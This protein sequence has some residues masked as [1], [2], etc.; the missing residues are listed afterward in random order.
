MMKRIS[1]AK[2]RAMM[3]EFIEDARQRYDEGIRNISPNHA[4]AYTQIT[5]KHGGIID[6]QD[7]YTQQYELRMADELITD[8]ELMIYIHDEE[9]KAL[10]RFEQWQFDQWC[11]KNNINPETIQQNYDSQRDNDVV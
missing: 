6:R 2:W 5:S 11:K 9:N 10:W 4:E 8:K 7:R 1:Q 3:D